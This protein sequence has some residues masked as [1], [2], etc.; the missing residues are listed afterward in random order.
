MFGV[1]PPHDDHIWANHPDRYGSGIEWSFKVGPV[2]G[3]TLNFWPR[4]FLLVR[5]YFDYLYLHSQTTD[6]EHHLM[7]LGS[8]VS[9]VFRIG[10]A[11]QIRLGFGIGVNAMKSTVLD[12]WG[13]D[14]AVGINPSL[15]LE[16]AIGLGPAMALVMG[17]KFNSMPWS[18]GNKVTWAP[19]SMLYVSLEFGR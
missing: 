9:W 1:V 16:F 14:V 19:I 7:S 4:P 17:Y 18:E 12:Y 6:N 11:F 8:R 10:R 5:V 13:Y 15:G 2:A 3:L